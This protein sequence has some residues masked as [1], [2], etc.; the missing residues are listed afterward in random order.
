M[1]YAYMVCRGKATLIKIKNPGEDVDK[2]PI[3]IGTFR[4]DMEAKQACHKHF[5]K[6]CRMAESFGRSSPELVFM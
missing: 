4:T 6:A 3:Q 2:K 5:E 1:I